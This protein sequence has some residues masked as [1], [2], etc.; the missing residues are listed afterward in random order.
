MTPEEAW[1]DSKSSVEYLKV[2]GSLA[3]VH[4]PDSKMIKLNDKS[5]KC[6]LLG[7]S[8]E[9]KAYGLFDPVSKKILISR[10]VSFEEDKAWD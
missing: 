8:E 1:N 4:V 2:F 5:L 6:I 7:V 9:S 10:D 3:P